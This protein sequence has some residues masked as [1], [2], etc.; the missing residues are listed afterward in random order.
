MKLTYFYRHFQNQ[1]RWNCLQTKVIPN[2]RNYST[3]SSCSI[4]GW[5]PIALPQF[6]LSMQLAD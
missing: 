4:K 3:N 5:L 6:L 1:G 2:R